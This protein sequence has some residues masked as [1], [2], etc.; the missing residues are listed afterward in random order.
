VS[1]KNLRL[2]LRGPTCRPEARYLP[3]GGRNIHRSGHSSNDRKVLNW[4]LAQRP[5]SKRETFYYHN[6]EAK[7]NLSS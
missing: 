5:F 2:G 4:Y 7:K 6:F 1:T 3:E